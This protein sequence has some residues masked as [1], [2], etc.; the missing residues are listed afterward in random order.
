LGHL[1]F[2]KVRKMFGLKPGPNPDCR[3]CGIAKQK[4]S[5]LSPHA[6][7]RAT[8]INERYH[9]DIGFTRG[10]A[11]PFQLYVDDYSRVT[12]LDLLENKGDTLSVWKELKILLENRHYPNKVAFVKSDNE[13]VYTSNEWIS[14]CRA[15]GV[16]HEFSA[17]YRHDQ[18]GVVESA[19]DSV[20]TTFRCMMV[21]G[22][23]PDDA[24]PDALMP[25][26]I[27]LQLLRIMGGLLKKGSRNEIRCE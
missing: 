5:K 4:K 17:R 23:A 12:H 18:N 19:I 2:D 26:E 27:I 25:L 14:W 13:F 11:H 21:Q 1:H 15:E 7:K 8:R 22:G 6:Y 9:I 24:I 3:T 16:E 10:S 20:G